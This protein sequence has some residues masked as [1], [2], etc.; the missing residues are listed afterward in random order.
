MKK[1]RDFWRRLE[2]S[3]KKFFKLLL[4][5]IIMCPGI[6]GLIIAAIIG[7]LVINFICSMY[8]NHR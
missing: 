7:R 5:L 4:I 3:E 1:V 8:N 2:P 6:I